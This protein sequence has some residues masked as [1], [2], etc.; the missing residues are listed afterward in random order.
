MLCVCISRYLEAAE[1]CDVALLVDPSLHKLRLRA[2]RARFHLGLFTKA[3]ED[4]TSILSGHCKDASINSEARECMA[5]IRSAKSHMDNL[6]RF[7]CLGSFDKA[8]ASAE[9]LLRLSPHCLVA[10][11]VKCKALC[12]LRRYEEAKGHIEGTILNQTHV[13]ILKLQAYESAIFPPPNLT[14]LQLSTTK[15]DD[16][17]YKLNISTASITEAILCLGSELGRVYLTSIKNSPACHS[18]C[19]EVMESVNMILSN[20]TIH[21]HKTHVGISWPWVKAAA[22]TMGRL[23]EQKR[24]ADR[25][26]RE[27]RWLEAE[28]VYSAA[29]KVPISSLF[30][31]LIH[32]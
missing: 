22:T 16:N 27:S 15:T 32:T 26:F 9:Q 17:S 20:L 14:T 6:S 23:L 5:N 11:V 29:I 10:H 25:N 21:L 31:W 1:D 28:S 30:K 19:T 13:T 2:G 3:G 8:L 18:C 24:L 7:E 12:S 4:F